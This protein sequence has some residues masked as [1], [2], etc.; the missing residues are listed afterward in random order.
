MATSPSA[1]GDTTLESENGLSRN[2][3]VIR[4]CPQGYC[5]MD[6]KLWLMGYLGK[7]Q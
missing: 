3:K 7:C 5:T 2:R 6:V 1:M 4:H